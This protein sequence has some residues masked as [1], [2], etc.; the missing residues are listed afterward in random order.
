R[1]SQSPYTSKSAGYPSPVRSGSEDADFSHSHTLV[2]GSSP[3]CPSADLGYLSLVSA[4]S[5]LESETVSPGTLKSQHVSRRTSTKSQRFVGKTSGK[6]RNQSV[7]AIKSEN[8]SAE[9]TRLSGVT[10]SEKRNRSGQRELFATLETK[11]IFLESPPSHFPAQLESKT[12]TSEETSKKGIPVPSASGSKVHRLPVGESAARP[13]KNT[14]SERPASSVLPKGKLPVSAIPRMRTKSEPTCRK[15]PSTD[16]GTRAA[17]VENHPK[18]SDTKQVRDRSRRWVRAVSEPSA[19]PKGKSSTGREVKP[20]ADPHTKKSEGKVTKGETKSHRSERTR[21]EV[22]QRGKTAKSTVSSPTKPSQAVKYSSSSSRRL[23]N[24]SG[25]G[26][27]GSLS[28]SPVSA[29]PFSGAS[30]P[31]STKCS[32]IPRYSKEPLRK[33]WLP[34]AMAAKTPS[35]HHLKQPSKTELDREKRRHQGQGQS[36][37]NHRQHQ[38]PEPLFKPHKSRYIFSDVAAPPSDKKTRRQRDEQAKSKSDSHHSRRHHLHHHHHPENLQRPH[39]DQGD[40]MKKGKSEQE[41]SSRKTCPKLSSQMR[42]FVNSLAD[43]VVSEAVL[44]GADLV[45]QQSLISSLPSAGDNDDDRRGEISEEVYSWFSNKIISQ[46]FSHILHGLETR[47][48]HRPHLGQPSVEGPEPISLHQ[49][50]EI[51]ASSGSP[52]EELSGPV[53]ESPVD[54]SATDSMATRS[55]SPLSVSCLTPARV[56]N[57]ASPSSPSLKSPSPVAFGGAGGDN[58]VLPGTT[59]TSHKRQGSLK[60][61]KFQVGA[62]RRGSDADAAETVDLPPH[63]HHHHHHQHS[64]P[65]PAAS[66]VSPSSTSSIHVPTSP[67]GMGS[68]PVKPSA[69]I[70]TPTPSRRRSSFDIASLSPPPSSIRAMGF[71]PPLRPTP[72]F[73]SGKT[74]SSGATASVSDP[75]GSALGRSVSKDFASVDL[76]LDIYQVAANIVDQVFQNISE[77]ARGRHGAYLGSYHAVSPGDEEAHHHLERRHYEGFVSN[78]FSSSVAASP[79]PNIERG[80]AGGREPVA[81]H[82]HSSG[83]RHVGE[84]E[85]GIQSSSSDA[86]PGLTQSRRTVLTPAHVQTG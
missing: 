41:D 48:H 50:R 35:S 82:S 16:S 60:V 31:S 59:M 75:S 53:L 26:A 84:R 43:R 73:A 14:G 13:K 78:I 9:Q 38:R 47:D 85:E 72:L 70:L 3:T 34:M 32:G 55:L 44:E 2:D 57:A 83:G 42:K 6:E 1:E 33:S 71:S 65:H 80:P 19:V 24:T 10:F 63:H 40:Q 39:R 25:E 67:V 74:E 76:T 8:L 37:G 69:N 22:S 86:T 30:G 49:L 23:S 81:K 20:G 28:S 5:H 36:G 54:P 7:G 64:Q 68:F 79:S 18:K 27:D 51:G 56:T 61:V 17:G 77:D 12:L 21:Q 66:P 15:S 62:G 45:S 46:V 52:G 4:S 29:Q 58:S 11:Q